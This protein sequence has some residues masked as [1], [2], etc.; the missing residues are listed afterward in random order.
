V[1]VSYLVLA[2]DVI[3]SPA[4]VPVTIKVAPVGS[5]LAV[6]AITRHVASVTA[7][8]ADNAGRV[9]GLIGTVVLAVSDAAAVLTG[10]VL[11]IAESAVESGEFPKL[12]ALELVLAFWNGGGL[13]IRVS[14]HFLPT[15]PRHRGK[16][17][18]FN[19]VV[20]EQLGLVD[21]LLGIGHDQ[22]MEVLLHIAVVGGVAAALSFLDGALSSDG[23][24]GARVLFHLLECV[25]TRADEQTNLVRES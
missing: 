17:Y 16:T 1:G 18:G 24:L 14:G 4:S 25:A 12:I 21:L 5:L 11:V 6:G 20:D 10:L 7:N 23:N 2:I 19:D 3:A 22:A 8:S 15:S 13:S 9:V